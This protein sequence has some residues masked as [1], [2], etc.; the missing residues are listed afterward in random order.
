MKYYHI[1]KK[2]LEVFRDVPQFAENARKPRGLYCTKFLDQFPD[3]IFFD[4]CEDSRSP[5]HLYSF[6]IP[7]SRFTT[8]VRR[9]Q[10]DKILKVTT[11]NWKKVSEYMRTHTIQD[12]HREFAGLDADDQRLHVFLQR[13]M[14]SSEN[15]EKLWIKD[16]Q[17]P[18][19][20]DMFPIG[21]SALKF[22]TV[23]APESCIWRASEWIKPKLESVQFEPLY[24]IDMPR[25]RR[26]DPL[27]MFLNEFTNASLFVRDFLKRPSESTKKKA[28]WIS[29][30]VLQKLYKA[31]HGGEAIAESA[32]NNVLVRVRRYSGERK[33]IDGT[34]HVLALFRKPKEVKNFLPQVQVYKKRS[35]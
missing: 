2:P 16:R 10:P 25:S 12:M 26:H 19:L 21:F 31:V 5:C 32:L 22:N 18:E 8:D 17:R 23:T 14:Y 33:I 35:K 6:D 27:A 4:V 28:K 29:A 34:L 30:E 9:S 7:R 20:A 13:F 15:I 3:L 24:P 1:T 11:S